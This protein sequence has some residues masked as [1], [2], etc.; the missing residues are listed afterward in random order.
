MN[1]HPPLLPPP[2]Q[3]SQ[4]YNIMDKIVWL[5]YCFGSHKIS[6]KIELEQDQMLYYKVT[7]L[8]ISNDLQ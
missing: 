4:P 8:D 1:F 3:I 7:A 5:W 6:K 2:P